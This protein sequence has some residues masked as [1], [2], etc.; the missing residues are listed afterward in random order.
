MNAKPEKKKTLKDFPLRAIGI[1]NKCKDNNEIMPNRF[2]GKNNIYS[3][4]FYDYDF[5][6]NWKLTYGIIN[7][8]LE[9]FPHD[10]IMYETKHGIHFISFALTKGLYLSKAR[11]IK[12]SKEL[13]SQDYWT[14][15]S[16]LT[17][18]ISQ[19]WRRNIWNKMGITWKYKTISDKPIFKGV[20]RLPELV[21][22]A[23]FPNIKILGSKKHLDFY[24]DF[25]ELPNWVYQQYLNNFEMLD[26]DIEL[27]HYP[28]KD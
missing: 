20:A 12:K 26:L 9:I 10:C 13:L 18:R 19:K 11:A 16:Y 1:S 25:L 22:Q 7:S 24:H 8:I 2:K 3:I 6:K 23:L 15:R 21:N 14:K 28:T 4:Q 17:L 5:D 27:H